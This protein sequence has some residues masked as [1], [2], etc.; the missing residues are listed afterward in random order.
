MSKALIAMSG[1]VDSAVAAALMLRKGYEGIG[2]HM[3]LYQGAEEDALGSRTCCSLSDS[4]DARSIAYSLGMKYYVFNLSDDFGEKVITPFIRSYLSGGT[5]NP[6]IECNRYMKFDKLMQRAQILG[7][8]KVVT[9]HYVR[10]EQ[11]GDKYVLKKSLNEEKDQ[12]YVLYFMTQEMLAHA[13]FPLGEFR[14]KEEVRAIAESMGFCNAE[15]PDSQDICFVPDGDYAAFI[16]KNCDS[17][18]GCGD[19]VTSDGIVLGR[20]KGIYHYTIGQRRG[21]GV[22]AKEPL[23]VCGKD[24]ANNRV[25]LGPNKELFSTRLLAGDF[26]WI[27]GDAPD[28]PVSCTARTRYHAKEVNCTAQAMEDGTV[29]VVFETPVRAITPGQA[30][31][32]YDGD[33]VLGGGTILP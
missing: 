13:D 7:C 16:E 28:A 21:L 5:P 18:T 23:Y 25:I 31:V 6:C 26:N 11:Q 2:V 32:L 9:G 29:S 15:K 8:D 4:E 24:M 17:C 3:K 19:F 20:H 10:V 14:S 22:S 12:S 1:G 30:V 33:I 27:S